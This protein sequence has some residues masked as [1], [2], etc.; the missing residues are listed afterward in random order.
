MDKYRIALIV[1]LYTL[2]NANYM[3]AQL[4]D[5]PDCEESPTCTK[6][7][8]TN[9]YFELVRVEGAAYDAQSCPVRT[10][11]VF[12]FTTA[13]KVILYK[14]EIRKCDEQITTKEKIGEGKYSVIEDSEHR[15]LVKIHNLPDIE[16]IKYDFDQEEVIK[17][18]E[19]VHSNE[20]KFKKDQNGYK[21]VLLE[22]MQSSEV[23]I[24]EFKL[25]LKDS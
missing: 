10:S 23:K 22:G 21:A 12:E 24:S 7:I 14:A 6:H 11:I 15:V 5:S 9:W 2:F 25:K 13:G 20:I 3:F 17:G 4:P 8:L 16:H 1:L 18:N 19:E